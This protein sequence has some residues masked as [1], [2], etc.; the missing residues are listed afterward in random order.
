MVLE[1]SSA[2]FEAYSF[3]LFM[4]SSEP[5]PY[6]S[7]SRAM[8]IPSPIK[9]PKVPPNA[10]KIGPKTIP[11]PGIKY[12]KE[13]IR[14]PAILPTVAPPKAAVPFVAALPIIAIVPILAKLAIVCPIK[15]LRFPIF[16]V[17]VANAPFAF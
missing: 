2:T 13:P 10:W 15:G 11:A 9:A 8:P 7:L 6:F 16:L 1:V 4:R 12:P 3:A 5:K 17:K 14:L